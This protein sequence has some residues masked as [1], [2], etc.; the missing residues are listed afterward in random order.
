MAP[1]DIYYNDGKDSYFSTHIDDDGS[2]KELLID[3]KNSKF[4]IRVQLDPNPESFMWDI[5]QV[6]KNDNIKNKIKKLL[7]TNGLKIQ[8]NDIDPQVDI[9]NISEEQI[10]ADLDGTTTNRVRIYDITNPNNKMGTGSQHF[11][12]DE[13]KKIIIE[14]K[15][16]S[17]I[18][19]NKLSSPQKPWK[20]F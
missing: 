7:T 13:G 4:V 14:H 20:N 1:F 11:Y 17:Y 8:V 2:K 5:V 16:K 3:D 19:Y 10:N 12:L 9:S 18:S 15:S 6:R